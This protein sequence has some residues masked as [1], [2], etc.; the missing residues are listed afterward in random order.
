MTKLFFQSKLH[1]NKKF[2]FKIL[3][4]IHHNLLQFCNVNKI[5]SYVNIKFAKT[6]MKGLI[7]LFYNQ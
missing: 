3:N 4:Y 1:Q 5:L 7:Y 2:F 6:F